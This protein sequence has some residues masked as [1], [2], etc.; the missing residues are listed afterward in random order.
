[1]WYVSDRGHIKS[2][3]KSNTTPWRYTEGNQAC[4][5]ES[6]QFRN[7]NVHYQCSGIPQRQWKTNQ[8]WLI[9]NTSGTA[10]ENIKLTIWLF[11]SKT[12][13]EDANRI[14]RSRYHK[15]LK[16]C[17]RDASPALCSSLVEKDLFSLCLVIEGFGIIFLVKK[18]TIVFLKCSQH[19]KIMS[20]LLQLPW[21][22]LL[23]SWPV[24]ND[25]IFEIEIE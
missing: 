16:N 19:W 11:Q 5:N 1:M 23:A 18:F 24:W 4:G 15:Y 3:T 21:P 12:Y 6:F 14:S 10:I 22:T 25:W 7:I 13:T 8:L 20:L 2:H 9:D 17:Q